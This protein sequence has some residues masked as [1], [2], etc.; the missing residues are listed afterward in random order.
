MITG[1]HAGTAVAIAREVGLSIGARSPDAIDGARLPDDEAVL[2][3]MLDRDGAVVY[4]VS[5]EEKLR[6]ARALQSRGHVVAMTG[7][8]VNDAPA[9]RQADVGVAMGKTGTDVAREAADLVLLD[10]DFATIVR[11]IAYGRRTFG[12][13]RHV[14]TYH[15]TANVAELAPF[16][17]WALSAGRFPLALGVLQI[18]C[19]DLVTDQLPA[20]ALGAE[21]PRD[22]ESPA[23]RNRQH[24]V[25]GDVLVRVFAVLG[26]AEAALELAAFVA[27]L[28]AAGLHPRDAAGTEA[29]LAASGAAFTAVI[30]GQAANM[31]ACRSATLEAWRVPP[32]SAAFL[33]AFAVVGALSSVLLYVPPIAAVL[34]HR[35]PPAI[36][37]A[38]A[39]LAAPAVL[40]A[41]TLQKRRRER[42]L[43]EAAVA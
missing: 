3:A 10:D 6:I 34:Q 17:L 2:G 37:V 13:L 8:G 32:A 14:L 42:R 25:D 26:P 30:I 22:E 33:G 31:F 28:F 5:P 19:F 40:I 29:L 16:V 35:P 12:N 36:G 1:D 27:V 24:L 11:A 39:A 9:L 43:H 23:P 38:V 20:L 4:R 21:A 41:D 18:L 15:L 7:D